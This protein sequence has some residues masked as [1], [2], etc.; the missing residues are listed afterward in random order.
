MVSVC[1]TECYELVIR[2]N[3]PQSKS[4][5]SSVQVSCHLVNYTRTGSS[6]Y[7]QPPIRWRAPDMRYVDDVIGRCVQS[8]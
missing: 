8:L 6:L 2:P 1:V 4:V 5:G 7:D 3:Q